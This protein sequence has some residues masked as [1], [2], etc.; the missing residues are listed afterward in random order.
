MSRFSGLEHEVDRYLVKE[1]QV[2]GEPQSIG[3]AL[4]QTALYMTPFVGS[5]LSIA[6]GVKDFRNGHILGGLWNTALGLGTGIADIFSL[7]TAGTAIRG[8]S[9]A[10]KAAKG[11]KGVAAAARGARAAKMMAN[12]GKQ[13]SMAG[14]AMRQVRGAGAYLKGG[15]RVL[16]GKGINMVANGAKRFAPQWAGKV[17]NGAR[18][19]AQRSRNAKA[20]TQAANHAG[21]MG[22]AFDWARNA[23]NWVNR[24]G[25]YGKG[26]IRFGKNMVMPGSAPTMWARARMRGLWGAGAVGN[27]AIGQGI[28]RGS[29]AIFGH[30][31]SDHP[32]GFEY[33]TWDPSTRK[34]EN[35]FWGG[36]GT[37]YPRYQTSGNNY[38]HQWG[39]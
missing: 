12:A 20:W 35:G 19:V 31:Y 18:G 29:E 3:G 8:L 37:G 9:A 1:A 28:N 16:A 17:M 27:Y 36:N 32:E 23:N 25:F 11:A 21:T 13:M 15:G 24:P 4:G 7:G 30:D 33:G 14:R 6:D 10:G 38:Y 5:A 34:Y 39:Y 2:L 22:R 26:L